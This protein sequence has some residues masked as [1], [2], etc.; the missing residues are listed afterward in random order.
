MY[1]Y[2]TIE[3]HPFG[4]PIGPIAIASII[5]SVIAS[6]IATVLALAATQQLAPYSGPITIVVVTIVTLA[7]A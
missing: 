7:I 3:A 6:I 5:V 1:R 4:G 2:G